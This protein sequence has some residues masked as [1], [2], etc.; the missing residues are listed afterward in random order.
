[1]A[2]NKILVLEK[3]LFILSHFYSSSELSVKELEKL[4]GIN[5][6]TV[7]KSLQSFIE[8]GYLEQDPVSKRYKSSIKILG[9]SGMVLR[10]MDVA[11]IA[12]PYLLSLRDEINETAF[13]SVLNDFDILVTDWEPSYHDAHI[14][15]SVGKR[16]PSYCSGAGKAILA[17]LSNKEINILLEKYDLT[18][19]TQ[20]TITCKENFLKELDKTLNRGYGISIEE[21]GKDVVAV[22][23]PIFNINNKVI[24]SVALAALKARV[25][26]E[27]EIERLGVAVKKAASNISKEL[28]STLYN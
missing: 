9:M 8:W 4:T 23:A 13:I 22:A 20:N 27:K 12:R 15:S 26:N 28:G 11:K 1:M 14:N 17:N 18:M 16:I 6:T 7:F 5:R 25:N 24:A 2:T 10:R 21:F 3:A 19:C